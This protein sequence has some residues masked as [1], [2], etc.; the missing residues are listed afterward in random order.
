M[1][2]LSYV[3]ASLALLLSLFFAGQVLSIS[4]AQAETAFPSGTVTIVVPFPAGGNSDAF[5]RFVAERLQKAWNQPVVVE[6]KPGAAAA[7][8]SEA[9]A[10]AT[11]DGQTILLG[12]SYMTLAPHLFANLPYDPQKDFTPVGVGT[13]IPLALF[14]APSL[15]AKTL[16]ELLA[17]LKAKPDGYNFASAGN[18]TLAHIGAAQFQAKTGT[19][20]VHIPYQGT[21]PA[22]LDMIG[23]RAHLIVESIASGLPYVKTGE[24][25]PILVAS[26]QR[27]TSLP[28]TPTSAEAGLD[29]FVVEAWNAFFVPAA[30][31]ADVVTKLNADFAAVVADKATVDWLAERS[32]YPISSSPDEFAK[33]LA[34]ESASWGETIQ[35]AGI[36]VE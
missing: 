29:G 6:N 19:K 23:G 2:L 17:V 27:N 31:P 11:P 9:V 35:S 26:T 14:A 32:M 10:K 3:R 8:G 12:A 22:L 34:A 25:V 16:D 30:T 15:N 13:S 36:K 18:A 4:A 28:D 1:T 7:I 33:R 20:L 24:L 5:A 21:A